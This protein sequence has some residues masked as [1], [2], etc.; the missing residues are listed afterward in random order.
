MQRAN[1][2]ERFVVKQLVLELGSLRKLV[3]GPEASVI[4][5]RLVLVDGPFLGACLLDA[6]R[7][8]HWP[9]AAAKVQLPDVHTDP[10]LVFFNR[11]AERVHPQP[12]LG[13]K[14]KERGTRIVVTWLAAQRERTKY[15][16]LNSQ[17]VVR[18]PDW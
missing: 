10:V 3:S 9:L 1:D 17:P 18:L 12:P 4:D 5:Q 7:Q 15:L 16:P 6:Y 14:E 8:Q 11:V 2:S 13:V